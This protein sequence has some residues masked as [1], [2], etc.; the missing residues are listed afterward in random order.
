MIRVGVDVGGTHTDLVLIDEATKAIFAY[1]VPSSRDP[2]EATVEALC[3]L[4]RASGVTPSQIGHFLHGTTIATNIVLQ[5]DGARTGLITTEGFRDILHI[6]RHKRPQTFSLQLDLPWQSYPLVAR[7]DRL[8]VRE[9]IAA[10]G[11]ILAPLDEVAARSAVRHLVAQGVEAIAVCFLFSFFN[12]VHEQRVGQIIE[13][14]APGVFVSLSHEVVPL[15]REYERFSTTALNAYIGPATV[16]YLERLSERLAANG[17]HA[18]PRLMQ[19]S[20][21]A[22]TRSAAVRRPVTLL[23]SGPVGGLLGG[24]F[25]GRSA[26][27]PSVVTLDVGG[28]SAD[29]GVAP[30]GEVLFKHVLDTRLGDYDAM[31][32]MVEVDAIGAGGGSVAYIDSG[33]QFQVGPRSAGSD[34]G[35]CCYSRGGQEPTATDCI[36]ALG[37]IDP[38]GFLGGRLPLDAGV[39]RIAISE[40]LARP[41]GTSVELAALAATKI[42]THNMVQAIEINSVRRGYDP[43]DFALVAF[44]GGGPLFACGIAREL[45]IPNVVVPPLPGLTSALGLLTTNVAYEQGATVMQLL[46]LADLDWLAGRF[47]ALEQELCTQLVHDGFDESQRRFLRFA[48]CRYRGQ[49]HELRTPA[50]PGAV[51]AAFV[52]ELRS[53]FDRQHHRAYGH[54]FGGREVEIVNIRVVGAG[55]V[56]ELQP[57][58]IGEGGATPPAGAITACCDAIFDVNG[59]PTP[60]C[61]PR[62]ARAQLRAGNRIAGPAIIDQ[63]DTTTVIPPGFTGRVDYF[64]NLV[65]AVR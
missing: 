9:R 37:H 64:G 59:A 18:E 61:T 27:F 20:G 43:R 6:A 60:V 14:E 40:R 33:G 62:F 52:Q 41:L 23:M 57:Q 56:P 34:P 50:P 35:P 48:D 38:G 54:V 63:M 8:T 12:P 10:S 11:D 58:R 44:G 1:K 49:G 65:I 15:Y 3:E 24:I 30:G 22:T 21:G 17:V 4:C 13:E 31:V 28:T 39:A 47:S 25:V 46:S 16:R 19:S 42:L 51:D 45:G 26:G 36:V 5:H 32:P 53:A 2:S 29:I 55:I 7:Q